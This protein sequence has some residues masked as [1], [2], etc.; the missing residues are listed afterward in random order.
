MNRLPL[1]GERVRLVKL[2]P[3][4]HR[5]YEKIGTVYTVKRAWDTRRGTCI[6]EEDSTSPFG[7]L[8]EFELVAEEKPDTG[9]HFRCTAE[10]FDG[11]RILREAAAEGINVL[12]VTIKQADLLPVECLLVRAGTDEERWAKPYLNTD[13]FI[14]GIQLNGNAHAIGE[15]LSDYRVVLIRQ[16]SA[17]LK[18]IRAGRTEAA[19]KAEEAKQAVKV[20][21]ESL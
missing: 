18:A 2:H 8:G 17:A 11:A 4:P 7:I 1:P 19:R 21:I 9:W 5:D 15:Q 10:T 12:K 20:T 3:S 6:T 14:Q 13:C 16:G